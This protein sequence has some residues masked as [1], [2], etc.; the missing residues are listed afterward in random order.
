MSIQGTMQSEYPDCIFRNSLL[1]QPFSNPRFLPFTCS[2]GICFSADK[3]DIFGPTS[4]VSTSFSQ[5]GVGLQST[6]PRKGH[7]RRHLADAG[8]PN[9]DEDCMKKLARLTKRRL[10]ERKINPRRGK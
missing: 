10:F 9:R 4:A 8:L 5:P 2:W 3:R 7:A 6:A 1:P